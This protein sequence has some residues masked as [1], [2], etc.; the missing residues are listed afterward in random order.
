[1]YDFDSIFRAFVAGDIA[2]FYDKLY[3][4]LLIYASRQLGEKLSYF[5][6][7]C[8]QDAVIKSYNRRDTFK[9]SAVWYAYLLKCIYNS[10]IDVI[11]KN[12]SH[13]S[14][15]DYTSKD[16][17]SHDIDVEILEQEILDRVHGAV[18]SLPP[19][20]RE[21]LRLSFAEGLK[22]SEIAARLGVAEITV[23]KH[24]ARILVMLRETLGGNYP[25][26]VIILLLSCSMDVF[27]GKI[28]G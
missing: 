26:E 28:V 14:F 12:Q 17:L 22:N 2:L 23:K 3:P 15:V 16:A 13:N 11:R 27:S 10:S 19:R 6:E 18:E 4:G 5:A 7:D 21:I 20:Y 25:V 9:N 1:M 24:K 8:V